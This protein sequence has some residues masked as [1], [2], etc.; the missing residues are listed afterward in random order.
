MP[1]K[2][3]EQ[4]VLL[5]D[6]GTATSQLSRIN[7]EAFTKDALIYCWA[8]RTGLGNDSI[9]SSAEYIET[10][11]DGL[12]SSHK[13]VKRYPKLIVLKRDEFDYVH[14]HFKSSFQKG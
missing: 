4:A 1:Q 14:I 13:E 3:T 8:C 5:C 6:E 11:S 2:I 12:F 10:V 9:D 7:P